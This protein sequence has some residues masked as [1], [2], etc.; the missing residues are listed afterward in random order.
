MLL[1]FAQAIQSHDH[2]ANGGGSIHDHHANGGGSTHCRAMFNVTYYGT[3]FYSLA[4]FFKRKK[5]IK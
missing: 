1:N 4:I 3:T 2:L 5:K